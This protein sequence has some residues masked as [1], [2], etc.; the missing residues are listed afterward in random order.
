MAGLPP[1]RVLAAVLGAAATTSVAILAASSGATDG[2]RASPLRIVSRPTPPLRVPHYRT[3][4]TYPQVSGPGIDLGRVNA[5]LRNTVL[6][7]QRRYARV[8]LADEAQNPD[9]IRM[10]YKG[11]FETATVPR[12]IS[13]N[14]VGVSALIT[15]DEIFPG[16]HVACYCLFTSV[17]FI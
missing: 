15:V 16:L 7:E 17:T 4:G 13:A 14:T 5:A 8:A 3:R 12:L 1:I 10:G 11:L 6:A 2:P 9:P